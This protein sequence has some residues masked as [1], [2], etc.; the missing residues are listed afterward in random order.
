MACDFLQWLAVPSGRDWIDVGCGTGALTQ[1][2]LE[3]ASPRSVK[4]VDLSPGFIEYAG[5]FGTSGASFEVGD[6]QLLPIDTASV[7][8]AVAGLVLNFVPDQLQGVREMA[9]VTR[10]NGLVGAYV[11]DYAEKMELLRHFW[12]AAVALDPSAYELHEGN[13][14]PICRGK[15][16]AELFAQAGLQEIEVRPIDI[17]TDFRSFDD[18]WSPFLGGQGPASNYVM[19]LDEA[20]RGAFRDRIQ[21]NLPMAEDGSIH[22]IAR[23]WAVRGRKP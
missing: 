6:A 2:I 22:L 3:R 20:R 21:S 18:F 10:P 19:S 23:A 17:P 15:P 4:G 7:D 16:L 1:V 8:T 9:R 11:W 5:R 12:D 14:F 13:R